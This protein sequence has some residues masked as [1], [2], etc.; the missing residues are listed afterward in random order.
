MNASRALS[1]LLNREFR[2]SFP[3]TKIVPLAEV[4]SALGGEEL[5]VCG[6]FV[7]IGGEIHGAALLLL[8][9]ANALQFGDLL[10]G[11]SPGAT[12]ELGEE[13]ISA[14]RETGNILA[15]SFVGA[16]ADETDLDL[17]L[18]VPEARVDM[19]VAVLD[20]VLAGFDQPGAHALLI[21]ADVFYADQEQVVCHLLIVLERG[22]ME[23]LVARVAGR[24]ERGDDGERR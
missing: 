9:L 7:G 13:E 15:A 14:L 17:R 23:R 3:E 1:D 2:V 5:P 20:S 4:A 16:I 22:S 10:L 21:E 12:E 8:P 18:R 11:R 24:G 6:V 19:C